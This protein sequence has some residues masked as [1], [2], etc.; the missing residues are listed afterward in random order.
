M[1]NNKNENFNKLSLKKGPN[2]KLLRE[3]KMKLNN[4]SLEL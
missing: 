2:N 4:L 1:N 3:Y